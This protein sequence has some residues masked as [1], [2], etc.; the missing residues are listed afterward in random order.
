M[1]EASVN[2][3]QISDKKHKSQ[4]IIVLSKFLEFKR[5]VSRVILRMLNKRI[6]DKTYLELLYFYRMG[7][8][9][10]L[11]NPQ[12]YNEKLQWLK[13]NDRNPIYPTLVDKYAVRSYI[14]NTIGENY[15]IPLLGGPWSN[16]DEID[17]DKLPDQFVLKCTHDSGGLVICTDKSNLDFQQTR[18]KINT[19]LKRNYYYRCREWPYKNVPPRIIAEQYM[20]D[21][22]GYELK[23]Y[24]FFCFDGEPKAMFV[25]T[26]RNIDTRFDFFDMNFAHLPFHNGHAWASREISK[27]GTFGQMRKLAAE[28]SKGFAQI[29]VDFYDINGKVYFGEL[30]LYHWSGMVPFEPEI[31]DRTFG[32][33]IQLNMEKLDK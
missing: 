26:D 18:V 16:F 24:K 27:P 19:A 31:W 2:N 32:D 33:W 13:L 9:L 30:T 6:P 4:E 1:P 21:E 7:K 29:R 12:T 5:W 10:D 28:L 11:N 8:K 17:F 3:S 22:S 15:L 20:I 23:D 25:A 14:A